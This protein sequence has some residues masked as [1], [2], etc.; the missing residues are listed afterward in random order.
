M[1][2]YSS[3]YKT[4]TK[5]PNAFGINKEDNYY[6][7]KYHYGADLTFEVKDKYNIIK[8]IGNISIG[9][10]DITQN[11]EIK[12]GFSVCVVDTD[13]TENPLERQILYVNN[14]SVLYVNEIM[15]G[16]FLL[17][18]DTDGNLLFNGRKV[19]FED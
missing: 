2:K 17:K 1:L 8:E 9:I 7:N 14:K 5:L 6:H 3:E 15:L 19:K 4:R 10:D 18:S 11:G 13:K 12:G 16:G